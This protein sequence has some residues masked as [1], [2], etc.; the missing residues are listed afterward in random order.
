MAKSTTQSWPI[1]VFSPLMPPPPTPTLCTWTEIPRLPVPTPLLFLSLSFPRRLHPIYPSFSAGNTHYALVYKALGCAWA[2]SAVED[3]E[4]KPKQ[5]SRLPIGMFS[6][7][8]MYA[9]LC[10]LFSGVACDVG[11]VSGRR[12]LGSIILQVW[13]PFPFG[14]LCMFCFYSD[15]KEIT[16]IKCV[17]TIQF[18]P[19][20]PPFVH[21]FDQRLFFSTRSISMALL[22]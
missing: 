22:C 16:F 9:Y 11:G 21:A 5:N 20:I 13:N 14:A 1:A 17:E 2:R 18:I 19:H 4:V 8:D 6:G 3:F 15:M 7:Q 12:C 10:G